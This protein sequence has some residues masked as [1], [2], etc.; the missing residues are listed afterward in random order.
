M[1]ACFQLYRDGQIQTLNSVDAAICEHMGEEVDSEYY[2]CNWF[3]IIGFSIAM[4]KRLGSAELRETVDGWY[5]DSLYTDAHF[6]DLTGGRQEAIDRLIKV[7]D[8][9]E[10]TY[11]DSS[12]YS[13]HRQAS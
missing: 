2:C 9:I 12:F 11:T 6:R 1:P 4:G 10:N 8:F 7:L 3:N 13:R 5:R